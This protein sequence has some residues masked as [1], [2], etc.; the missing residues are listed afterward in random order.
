MYHHA[1]TGVKDSKPKKAMVAWYQD[2][3]RSKDEKPY[4]RD[5]SS[6]VGNDQRWRSGDSPIMPVLDGE[7]Q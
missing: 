2:L 1:R 4:L 3:M 7:A 6:L 5:K